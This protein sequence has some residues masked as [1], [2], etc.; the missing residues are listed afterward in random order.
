MPVRLQLYEVVGDRVMSSL[1]LE[2]CLMQAS[3]LTAGYN[4]R[5]TLH[6]SSTE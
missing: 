3:K 5:L 2:A 6:E 4:S 1:D